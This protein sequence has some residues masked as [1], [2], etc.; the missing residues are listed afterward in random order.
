MARLLHRY[1]HARRPDVYA[2]P[3]TGNSSTPRFYVTL[4]DVVGSRDL[5]KSTCD[6]Y[7]AEF[8]NDLYGARVTQNLLDEFLSLGKGIMVVGPKG[9]R[10]QGRRQ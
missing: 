8:E 1:L 5:L 9:H 6:V 3:Y 7:I 4:D 2:R 10:H